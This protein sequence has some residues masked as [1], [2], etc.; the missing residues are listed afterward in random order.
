MVPRLRTIAIL[1]LLAGLSLGVFTSRALRAFSTQDLLAGVPATSGK[2]RIDALVSV[3]AEEFELDPIGTDE[4]RQELIRYDRR[5]SAFHWELRQ[6]N[7]DRFRA[8]FEE[9][10]ER[11][12][13]ILKPEK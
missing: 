12:E 6:K 10:S 4:I 3:Y 13:R 7:K 2:A 5:L 8:L 11:I 1:M 9:A